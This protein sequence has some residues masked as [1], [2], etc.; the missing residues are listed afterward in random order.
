MEAK[1]QMVGFDLDDTVYIPAARGLELFNRQGLLEIDVLYEEKAPI[2]EVVEGVKRILLARHGG[3]DFTITRSSRC[4][5]C[6]ARS[7]TC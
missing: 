5:T 7:S 6:S 2:E 3:E 1:G 4:S